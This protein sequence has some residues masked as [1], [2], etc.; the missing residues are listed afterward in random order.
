MAKKLDNKVAIVTGGARGIGAACAAKL[1]EEGATVLITDVLDSVGQTTAERLQQLG[2]KVQYIYHD[3]GD[4]NAWQT[5]V[6][7]ALAQFGRIDCLV[8]NAGINYPLTLEDATAQ[9]F[10]ELLEINVIG[11]F[12]GMQAVLPSMKKQGG[13]SIINISSN[14]TRK[15][16]AETTIY[17]ASKAAVA[18]ITKSAAINFGEKGYNIRVNSVHPGATKTDMTGGSDV[19]D[20]IDRLVAAVPMRR[21]GEPEDIAAVVAFLAS[22]DSRYMTAAELFVDGGASVV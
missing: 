10:R 22:D 14:S 17:G 1:C 5:V 19:A 7:H 4:E 9:Q 15:M 13:G 21:M 12:Y 2:H 18:Y 20:I 3:V 6:N 8:N 11:T 16:V